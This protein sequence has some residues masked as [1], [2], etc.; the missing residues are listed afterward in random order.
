M[1]T[2]SA[3]TEV[4]AE[5]NF[6][7]AA[8]TRLRHAVR[9]HARQA[10]LVDEAL[11][12]FVIAVHELVTNAVRHGGGS[13]VLRLRRDGDTLVCD[14]VDRGAGFADGIPV[15]AGPPPAEA[16]G[17]RGILLAR[18]LADTLLISDGPDGVTATVTA[19]LA[20]DG[21]SAVPVQTAVADGY[22]DPH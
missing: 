1:A 5:E 6:T 16:T 21:G 4:L 10:G 15:A 8:V 2:P 18:H 13:G 20:G 12:D 22:P 11:D 17:G 19:C 9:R 3:H 7:G 14:V